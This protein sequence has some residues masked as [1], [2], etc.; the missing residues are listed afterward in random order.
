MFKRPSSHATCW[1]CH[2]CS[3]DRSAI[4]GR[5]ID[6]F[7]SLPSPL[8]APM[9]LT[10][11]ERTLAQTSPRLD[12]GG[13]SRV[14]GFPEGGNTVGMRAEDQ[15]RAL[16]LAMNQ[17]VFW[18]ANERL[19]RA[20]AS[21]RFETEQRVPFVCEC[22]DERCREIVMVSIEEYEHI[23]AIRPG[24][25]WSQATKTTRKSMNGSSTRNTVIPS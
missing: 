23:R 18:G 21:H 11:G 12:L 3:E 15:A 24:S 9:R 14:L 2:R 22:A 4:A 20:A 16:K 6:G 1:R 8:C 19:R 13:A 25:C 10:S 5:G 17:S 7:G